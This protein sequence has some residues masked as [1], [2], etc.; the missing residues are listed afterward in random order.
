MSS[1]LRSRRALE[2]YKK[3]YE[4]PYEPDDTADIHLDGNDDWETGMSSPPIDD[5]GEFLQ[6]EL[7]DAKDRS[8]RAKKL[9]EIMQRAIHP[10]SPLKPYHDAE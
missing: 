4:L 9:S 7:Q 3:T 8:K 2:D 6:V 1:K 5:E 10:A